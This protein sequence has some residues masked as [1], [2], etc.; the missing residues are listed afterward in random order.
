MAVTTEGDNDPN[1]KPSGPSLRGKVRL[2]AVVVAAALPLVLEVV[3]LIVIPGAPR[4][5]GPMLIF[6]IAGFFGGTVTLMMFIAR[7][8]E[9]QVLDQV[10]IGTAVLCLLMLYFQLQGLFE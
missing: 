1:A 8:E 4:A 2:L 9:H 6:M 7:N 5:P 10:A 3:S